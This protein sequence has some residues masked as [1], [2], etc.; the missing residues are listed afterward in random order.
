MNTRLQRNQDRVAGALA[1][2][3]IGAL[4]L[5]TM[6]C[7]GGGTGAAPADLSVL[8]PDLV[9]ADLKDSTYPPGPYAQEGNVNPGDVLPDF[10]FQG[11]FSPT[12]TMGLVSSQTYGE[13][14][15][16]MLHDSGAK[17]AILGLG[18]FW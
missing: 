11:Y 16:G 5:A 1:Q 3:A 4:A 14:T 15:F 2:G 6:A 18:A 8:P 12:G 17:Y 13:V 7:G 9:L 10:T